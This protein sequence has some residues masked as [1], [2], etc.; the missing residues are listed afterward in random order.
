MLFRSYIT[1]CPADYFD[2]ALQEQVYKC[3]MIEDMG[4]LSVLSS[5][6]LGHLPARL[7]DFYRMVLGARDRLLAERTDLHHKLQSSAAKARG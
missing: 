4:G 7:V 6:A 1:G 3:I 5:R 2:A